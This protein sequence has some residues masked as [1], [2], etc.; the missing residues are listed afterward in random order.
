[1]EYINNNN[2]II[3]YNNNNNNN[4]NVEQWFSYTENNI[5]LTFILTSFNFTTIIHS[6]LSSW[7]FCSLHFFRISDESFIIINDNNNN[8]KNNN[9]YYYYNI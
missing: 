4:N 6:L 3:Q 1:M 9:D 5:I 2:N 7:I 8:N